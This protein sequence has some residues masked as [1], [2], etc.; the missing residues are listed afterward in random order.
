MIIKLV[1]SF[2][3]IYC[4]KTLRSTSAEFT[5]VNVKFFNYTNLGTSIQCFGKNPH[6]YYFH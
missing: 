6:T 1:T 4:S 5:T 3:M 2:K